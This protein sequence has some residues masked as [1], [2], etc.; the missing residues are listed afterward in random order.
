MSGGKEQ[1]SP[2]VSR[3]TQQ[4]IRHRARAIWWGDSSRRTLLVALGALVQ[5]ANTALEVGCEGCGLHQT[6]VFTQEQLNATYQEAQ[7]EQVCAS[8]D[9]EG[10]EPHTHALETMQSSFLGTALQARGV[11][12]NYNKVCP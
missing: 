8:S 10:L 5:H 3:E 7:D 6:P 2:G 12:K 9:C 4:A 1:V 11:R